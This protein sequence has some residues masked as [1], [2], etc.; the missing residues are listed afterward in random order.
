MSLLLLFNDTS[1]KFNSWSTLLSQY[2]DQ[3]VSKIDISARNMRTE[4]SASIYN[5]KN[6]SYQWL[7]FYLLTRTTDIMRQS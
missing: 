1:M 2:E 4:V 5:D 7:F 3:R 6:I